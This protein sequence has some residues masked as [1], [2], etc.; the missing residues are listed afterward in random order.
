MQGRKFLPRL[1]FRIFVITAQVNCAFHVQKAV[2]LINAYIRGVNMNT[3]SKLSSVSFSLGI[4]SFVHLF[5]L[6]KAVVAIILGASAIKDIAYEGKRGKWM[7]YTGIV[8]ACI[9]IIV[10]VIIAIVKGPDMFHM[11]GN[12]K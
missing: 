6:E 4:L 1:I 9:Y 12:M 10:L 7:A 11:M 8:L 2:N 3:I 5:E